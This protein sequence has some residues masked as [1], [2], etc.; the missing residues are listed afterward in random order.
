M[1]RTLHRTLVA[2]AVIAA[3]PLSARAQSPVTVTGRVV[4]EAGQPLGSVQVFI[5]SLNVGTVTRDDGTYTLQV[6]ARAAGTTVTVG[7]RRIGFNATSQQVA[8]R[9]TS[10]AVNFSL[11][12]AATQLTGVVVTA[13]GIE[14]DKS[15]LGTAQQTVTSAELTQ[16]KAPNLVNQLQGKV[17]GVN[18]TGAGTPGGS[19]NII[20]R[21][22]NSLAGNNQPLFVVDGIPVASNTSRGG[23]FGNGYDYG[24]AISDLNPDDIE[25]MSILKGPNA[26]ALYGSRAS[27]GVVMIT[28]KKGLATQGRIRSEFN[29][30]LTYETPSVMPEW[31]NQYG[32]GAGGEF[33]Y[34][35]GAGRG[36]NDGADQSWGPKLDGRTTGCVFV[37]PNAANPVYDTSKQC[38]QFTGAGLP[39]QAH[40]DN[41]DQFFGTGRTFS[42]TLAVNG[43]TERANAR[44]SLGTDQIKGYIPSN[45]FQKFTT[46]LAGNLQVNPRLS[47]QASLQYIRNNGLNRPG[48]GYS[49]SVLEQFFWYGR[50]VDMNALRNFGQ[51]GGVNGGPT[52]REFNWNYNYHNNPFWIQN[53]NP[54]ND[55]RDRVQGQIS[56]TYRLADGISLLARTGSDIYRL[57]GQQNYAPGYINATY[58]NPSYQGGFVLFNDYR[59]ENNTD[60]IL[61]ADRDLTSKVRLLATVGGNA[62]REQF[63]STQQ[64]TTG[65]V[66]AGTYNISNTALDP[67]L[68]QSNTRRIVNGVYGSAA[69]TWDGWWTVEGTARND[70]SSTLP[71]GENS[72]FYPS[73]N[74]SLVLTDAIPALKNSVL[75]YA[76]L[77]GGV[78]RVGADADPYSLRTVFNGNSVRFNG[79]PQFSLG[80]VLANAALKPEITRSNEVGIEL[81][82]FGGRA[83]FDGTYYDRN[84][85]NQ[86]FNVSISPASG[87]SNRAINA[88]RVRNKGVDALLSVTPVKNWN[89]VTWTSSF[90]YGRNRNRIEAL[91]EGV[92]SLLISQGLFGDIAFENKAGEPAGAIRTYRLARNEAG[93]L[94]VTDAGTPIIEDTLSTFGYAQPNWTGGWD[95][96][97]RFKGITLRALLDF[98]RGGKMVSY[99]NYIGDY[100]GVLQS[101][102]RGREVD[103]NNPGYVVQG[104]RESDGAENTTAITSERYHQSLFGSL[105]NYIYDASYTR[106]REVRVGFDLPARYAS[107]INATAVSIALTGRNLV[108]WSK[109][110]NVDP[111]FTYNTGNLQGVEYAVPSN[112][113][114]I[115]F[116]VRVT[117]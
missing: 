22:Q 104:V 100:S 52:S 57:G 5:Q 105:E 29:S 26:A 18:I 112:P 110:P 81:G 91:T 35:N 68:S 113:R 72:Y 40:P 41:V 115:G 19:T 76:K 50:Q 59:N 33:A 86:I 32:Q 94:L 71:Q 54:R 30:F 36:V 9:G 51:G 45:R 117:P 79:Q 43:G 83:T 103:W 69:F 84:T 66:T 48:T 34:V 106:L 37:D 114:S 75:E 58:V 82:F 7:A 90:N 46:L 1:Y 16:T 80:D 38:L 24:N 6:P 78:A 98:R 3:L 28:T 17:S 64:A 77:R 108:L 60:V 61:T 10:V 42:S 56:A 21:G 62:R 11:S 39:W 73:V 27:N 13:Q 25:T 65:L 15:S 74:T 49:N 14:R 95:N 87:F 12:T 70:W 4:S 96:E 23:S 47:T 20:I 44:L 67:T 102:L 53:A 101:S 88:G 116:S 63:N 31:Q 99:S 107:R 109:V 85:S 89:N 97:F 2:S 111:E 8:L 92:N 93:R 55:S